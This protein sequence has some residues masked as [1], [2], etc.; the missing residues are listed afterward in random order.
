M[1]RRTIFHHADTA[2]APS[3]MSNHQMAKQLFAVVDVQYI[4][5]GGWDAFDIAPAL[6]AIPQTG[7]ESL[8][9]RGLDQIGSCSRVPSLLYVQPV[10]KKHQHM[11][12]AGIL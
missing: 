4:G 11:L 8:V 6:D 1:R 2:T 7:N 12:Y 10:G 9:F 5:R 3:E